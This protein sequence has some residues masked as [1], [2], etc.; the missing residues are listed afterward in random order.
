MPL[1][2]RKAIWDGE[3]RPSWV[4]GEILTLG[5][6]ADEHSNTTVHREDHQA[7]DVVNPL[8]TLRQMAAAKD[9]QSAH[10][11]VTVA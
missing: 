2:T 11:V 7:H 8:T 3:D 10:A 6:A 5:S 4:A 9:I 1:H